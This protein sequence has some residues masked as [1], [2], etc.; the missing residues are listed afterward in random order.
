M[1]LGSGGTLKR[2]SETTALFASPGLTGIIVTNLWSF[3][4]KSLPRQPMTLAMLIR[5]DKEALDMFTLQN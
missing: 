4:M 5:L 1:D 2:N 3:H